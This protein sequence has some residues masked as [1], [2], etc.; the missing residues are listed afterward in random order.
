MKN[1]A[2]EYYAQF[3][4]ARKAII[5]LEAAKTAY[6]IRNRT[7]GS[8]EVSFYLLSHSIELSIKAVAKRET[9]YAPPWIHDKQKLAEEYKNE[10]GFSNEEVEIIMKLKALNDGPGGLRYE[11]N[12]RG[13]FLP[14]TFKSGVKIV[15]RL[16][17]T[18]KKPDQL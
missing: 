2:L 8:H 3:P 4:F 18:F 1:L 17:E 11:N 7:V 10:C 6:E 13:Q 5:F 9:G 12:P 16:L 15:E 14:S